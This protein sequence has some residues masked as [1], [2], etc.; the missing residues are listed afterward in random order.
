LYI[1]DMISPP[2]PAILGVLGPGQVGDERRDRRLVEETIGEREDHPADR[3]PHG[4]ARFPDLGRHVALHAFAAA[5][6]RTREESQHGQQKPEARMLGVLHAG[7]RWS[8]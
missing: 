3:L 5:Q 4:E 8:G 2:G 6:Q 1:L 7:R